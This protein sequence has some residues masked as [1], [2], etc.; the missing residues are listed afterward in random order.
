MTEREILL[1]N[2]LKNLHLLERAPKEVILRDLMGL[3][4]Q[5]SRNPQIS[6][7]LRASD[8]D[9]ATWGNGLAKIW[10][11]RGTIHVIPEEELGLHL[12]AKGYPMPFRENW[13]RLSVADQ[14]KWAP[15]IIDEIRKGNET[16]DGLKAACT[17]A[18]MDDDLR[19]RVFYGWG[20]LIQEMAWRGMLVCCTGTDKRYR[21]PQDVSFMDPDEARRILLSRYFTSYGPATVKDCAAFFGMKMI[22][23]KP[24]LQGILAELVCSE[25]AGEK[26]YH[27]RPL[28]EGTIPD[29]VLIPGFD[30][31]VLGYRDRSRM[32]DPRHAR[33][34]T[35]VAGIVFP[36]ILLRGMIRARWKLEGNVIIVTPFERLLK[37]DMTAIRREA[38]RR[39]GIEEVIF[40]D[41]EE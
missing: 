28:T 22:Q 23:L 20:G 33:K 38:K 39:L 27:A 26:Y 5:F 35:N 2:S 18:G 15:F 6:L 29:C 31:L 11:H 34:L 7:R 17:S 13:T 41:I 19:G 14:E 3:Q 1:Y 37:K 9:D 8:Y 32:L 40:A 36:A 12:S 16:R 24:L 25:I 30:Q 21:I 10:S 4:A